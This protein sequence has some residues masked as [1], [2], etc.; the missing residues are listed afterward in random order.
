MK[1]SYD[2]YADLPEAVNETVFMGRLFYIQV[3]LFHYPCDQNRRLLQERVFRSNNY[4]GV[5]SPKQK[6]ASCKKR[7]P[8]NAAEWRKHENNN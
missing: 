3:I 5:S 7:Q 6:V 1:V 8:R 2:L 4:S